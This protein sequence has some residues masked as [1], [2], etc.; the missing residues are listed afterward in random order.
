MNTTGQKEFTGRHM[1]AIMVAFFGFIIA[2]N[3]TMAVIA[4]KTWTG[5]V[6]PNTYVASQQFNGKVAETKAQAKLHWNGVIAARDGIVSY[7]IVNSSSQSVRVKSVSMK[8]MRPVD[9]R[10]DRIETLAPSP[11]GNHQTIAPL[12]DGV[13]LV[14]VEADAGLD[15]PFRETLRIHIVNGAWQ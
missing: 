4:N 13:W 2:V 12:A 7:H 1:F 15:R 11:G 3:I 8:F 9:D 14:E 5:L 10:E 6:V